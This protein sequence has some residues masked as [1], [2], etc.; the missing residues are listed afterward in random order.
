[1]L[2][3]LGVVDPFIKL[4]A[5]NADDSNRMKEYYGYYRRAVLL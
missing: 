1:M 3:W 5:V 2:E 4:R